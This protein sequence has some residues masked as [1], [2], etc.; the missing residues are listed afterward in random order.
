M[1]K[2]EDGIRLL[3]NLISGGRI[4][5]SLDP[6][7]LQRLGKALD[8]GVQAQAAEEKPPSVFGLMRRLLSA[9]SLRGLSFM[10]HILTQLG[11]ATRKPA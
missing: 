7:M 1:A 4:V 6:N 10:T 11:R 2:S 9:D 8:S 3:R 5:A